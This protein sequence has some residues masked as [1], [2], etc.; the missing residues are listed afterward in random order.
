MY[1]R[2]YD[3]RPGGRSVFFYWVVLALVYLVTAAAGYALTPAHSPFVS[4]T[5]RSGAFLGPFQFIL[6]LNSVE[7]MLAIWVKN[8]MVA[9]LLLI[10]GGYL[11]GLVSYLVVISN[12]LVLGALARSLHASGAPFR[13]LA[14]GLLPHGVIELSTIFFAGALAIWAVKRKIGFFRR[15]G[16]GL[17]WVAPLLLAAAAVET[18]VTPHVMAVYR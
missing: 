16:A 12:G 13:F 9:L 2:T 18:F 14:A 1:I 15:M 6:G 11:G 10:L 3:R 5:I 17:R 8:L 4:Q 7:L